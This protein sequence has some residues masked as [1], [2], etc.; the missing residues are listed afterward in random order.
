MAFPAI[1]HVHRWYQI[2]NADPPYFASL[3]YSSVTA[4]ERL[5]GD[6]I[7]STKMSILRIRLSS[8]PGQQA[9]VDE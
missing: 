7:R 9:Q 2:H 6:T 1:P 3:P 5:G 4:H 8:L